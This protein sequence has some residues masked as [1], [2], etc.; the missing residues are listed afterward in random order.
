MCSLRILLFVS[1]KL[2]DTL[3][4]T[5]NST[6]L[7]DVL[8][9][10]SGSTT[11]QFKYGQCLLNALDYC[12]FFIFLWWCETATCN[13]PIVYHLE[14][15]WMKVEYRWD[16]NW[17]LKIEVFEDQKNPCAMLL[18]LLQTLPVMPASW[19]CVYVAR[20]WWWNFL[21]IARSFS[22]LIHVYDWRSILFCWAI[23]CLCVSQKHAGS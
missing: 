23:S 21:R 18:C 19:T 3:K 11:N 20:I 2:S 5:F 4:Q 16:D 7:P 1:V 6:L 14:D 13:G 22:V 15:R 9:F 17:Q 10:K 12:F 8:V